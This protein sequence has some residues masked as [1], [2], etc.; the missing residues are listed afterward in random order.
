M[1]I[2]HNFISM[3]RSY[4]STIWR[5]L[6]RNRTYTAINIAG[7]AL[8]ISACL[9]IYLVTRF[10][11][12]YDNFHPDKERIYRIVSEND[13]P[14]H[15]KSYSGSIPDP[16]TGA[17][18]EEIT[19]FESVALFKS[20]YAK[21]TVPGN[22]SAVKKFDAPDWREGKSDMIITEPQY[23]DIFSYRWLAGNA[24][25][26]LKEPF[27]VVLTESK[28]RKYFGS[29]P[30]QDILGR[31]VIYNDS[32][33]LTVSGIVKDLP[34]NTDF[35]FRDF[36]SFS[37]VY[38]SF[39]R[40]DFNFDQWNGGSRHTQGFVK[41]A[42][43]TALPQIDARLAA[44][45]A[46]HLSTADKTRFRLQPLSDLHFNADYLDA[47]SRKAHLPTLY[48]L[49]GIAVFILI[50]AVINFINLTTVQSVERAKEIG[51]RKVLGSSRKSLVLRFLG[52]TFLLTLLALTL[53][54]LCI[55]PL[56]TAFRSF[57]P[58]GAGLRLFSPATLGFLLL[59]MICTTLLAGLYPARILSACQPVQSLKGALQKNGRKGS[60]RKGLVIFQFAVSLVF[61]IGALVIGRQIGFMLN[62]DL[63]FAKDAIINIQTN[64]HYPPEKKQ[65]LAE[66]IR[67]LPDVDM[68]SVSDGTPMEKSHWAL[69]FIYKDKQPKEVACQLQWIDERFIPLY[70]LKLVAGRNVLPS[71]TM[72][73]LL[74][75]EACARAIGF[76]DPRA[77][78]GKLAQA[79]NG[80]GELRTCPIVGVV[81]DFH[82][83]SLHE[84]IR[85]SYF[86]TD[87]TFSW[88]VS[89]KL[90]T[91]GKQ[92][93]HFKAT[94]AEIEKRWSALYPEERFEYRFFDAVIAGFYEQEQKTARLMNA[95]MIIAVFISCMGLFGLAAFTAQQRTKEIGI[96][97]VL[98]ASV[99]NITAMLSK[100]FIM[101][102]VIA[103]L[104]AIP[105]AWYGMQQWLARFAYS[106][107]LSWWIFALAGGLAIL[108]ALATVSFHAAKAA[109]VNPVKSLRS[110]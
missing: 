47:Y 83:Q 30:L 105:V 76:A 7:L 26:A 108:I 6:W 31:T 24:A 88:S 84:P 73:E 20:Y 50:I 67:R 43:G 56:L 28:A 89:V 51:V 21:V 107:S 64:G 59:I 71:D 82:T 53:S 98:G 97:K 81:A 9:V 94:L 57:I 19:G 60:L 22:T 25:T 106:I 36:I 52:E 4:I 27:K 102:V 55:H 86:T 17:A 65:M 74:I 12:S 62:K 37:T 15:G 69:P 39:L 16:L 8:G 70:Q 110:E 10:E 3:F 32:L 63:G 29:I 54:L 44:F 35:I 72:K 68:V 101:L 93:S 34:V 38:H 87:K 100:D 40:S 79:Y 90:H 14:G 80:K 11:L 58:D 46:K 109:V 103:L 2:S 66:Q 92:I 48:G 77:A 23:F 85:P 95:A 61:I 33:Q 91:R 42:R 96:R 104:I 41:L 78:I 13:S 75:N 1:L 49:I 45:S 18:R 5:H 99:V